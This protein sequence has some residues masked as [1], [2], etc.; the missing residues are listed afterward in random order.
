MYKIVIT[1]TLCRTF[2]VDANERPTEALENIKERYREGEI[3]LDADDF[4]QVD[5]DV[6]EEDE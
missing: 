5:F 4:V 6:F 2:N 1:E 3:V